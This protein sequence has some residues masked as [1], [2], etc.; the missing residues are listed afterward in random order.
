[1]KPSVIALIIALA[2]MLGATIWWAVS[3]LAAG[4]TWDMPASTWVFMIVGIIVAI[5]IGAGLM[6]LIFWGNRSGHDEE[7]HRSAFDLDDDFAGDQPP[8]ADGGD[9]EPDRKAPE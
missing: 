6:A 8:P 2:V 1:M 9:G 3:T 5:A 7:V 4:G